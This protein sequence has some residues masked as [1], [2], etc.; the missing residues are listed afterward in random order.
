MGDVFHLRELAREQP[1]QKN[2]PRLKMYCFPFFLEL[3]TQNN[4][5]SAWKGIIIG[6]YS[7]NAENECASERANM[8]LLNNVSQEPESPSIFQPA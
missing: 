5:F 2:P 3:Q 7:A 1:S 6:L 4:H 8:T